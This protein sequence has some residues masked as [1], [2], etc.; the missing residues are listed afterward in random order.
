MGI[1]PFVEI[2]SNARGY[3]SGSLQFLRLQQVFDNPK[4]FLVRLRGLDIG[5]HHTYC[6]PME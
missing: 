1:P 4:T 5:I 2:M 6:L 3:G